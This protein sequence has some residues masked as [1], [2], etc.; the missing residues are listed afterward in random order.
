MPKF[1]EPKITRPITP[2]DDYVS[3]WVDLLTYRTDKEVFTLA[4]QW[5]ADEELN[6][7]CAQLNQCH[8]L[9]NELR[10][11]LIGYLLKTRR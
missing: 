6:W 3:D 5:G 8:F 2:P 10:I 11:K 4:A 9:P 7:C 1:S